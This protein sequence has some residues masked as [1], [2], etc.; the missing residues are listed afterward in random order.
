MKSITQAFKR[1]EGNSRSRAYSFMGALLLC[2]APMQY[3]TAAVSQ[4]PLYLGGGGVPGNLVLTP[5]VEYPTIQSLANLGAYTTNDRFE[6]Y[7]DPD[8]CYKYDYDGDGDDDNHFY[9]SSK[10]T[11]RECFG[12][13]EW[14]GNFLN[15]ATT[16]TIGPFRKVLTGG[17]RVKD[18]DD[19][20]WLEKARHPGQSG[21]ALKIISG[22]GL[23]KGA[24]P[25]EKARVW[26]S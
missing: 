14:S 15:W 17:Y 4:V 24:T 25:F 11:T 6:G 18:E 3:T 19:E 23:I 10:T 22:N 7:F 12:A 16:Q 26:N 1:A 21:L 9:P 2:L 5:S 20:T 8:K 13:N